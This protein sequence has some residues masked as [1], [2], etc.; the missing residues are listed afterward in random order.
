[1][2]NINERLNNA[3][4]IGQCNE[5]EKNMPVSNKYLKNF[6][7]DDEYRKINEGN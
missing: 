2:R 1:M 6:Q 5:A 3:R 7:T 4:G